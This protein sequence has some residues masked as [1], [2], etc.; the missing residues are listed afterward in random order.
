MHWK[1]NLI[2]Y[3]SKFHILFITSWCLPEC[4]R[5]QRAFWALVFSSVKHGSWT[6]WSLRSVGLMSYA[7]I[8]GLSVAENVTQAKS[9]LDVFRYFWY[10]LRFSNRMLTDILTINLVSLGIWI[11]ANSLS[12]ETIE[13]ICSVIF[14]QMLYKVSFPNPETWVYL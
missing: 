3:V 10:W 6:R 12:C 2:L 8:L 1:L 4:C 11:P 14:T 7:D 5:V 13:I 9:P